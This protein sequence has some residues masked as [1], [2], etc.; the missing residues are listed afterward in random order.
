MVGRV[1]GH[2][3]GFRP[4]RRFRWRGISF[5]DNNDENDLVAVDLRKNGAHEILIWGEHRK[6]GV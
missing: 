6:P 4:K 3:A 2:M 5:N 1:V